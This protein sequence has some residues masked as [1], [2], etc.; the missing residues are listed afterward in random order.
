ML[1]KLSGI[2][3]KLFPVRLSHFLSYLHVRFFSAKYGTRNLSFLFF[4]LS[5]SDRPDVLGGG[6]LIWHFFSLPIWIV[7]KKKD[8]IEYFGIIVSSCLVRRPS[9][10]SGRR[11]LLFL[12]VI[13]LFPEQIGHL[14]CWFHFFSCGK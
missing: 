5:V 9:V 2:A 11:K 8:I 10:K 3:R 7:R 4:Y 13:L 1:G 6:I 12:L 14:K